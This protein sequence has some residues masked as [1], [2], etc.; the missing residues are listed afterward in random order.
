[1]QLIIVFFIDYYQHKITHHGKSNGK[2]HLADHR[3]KKNGQNTIQNEIE[4]N[5]EIHSTHVYN[6]N[7]QRIQYKISNHTGLISKIEIQI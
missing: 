2:Q 1:M 5:A 4:L 3:K 6:G 7:D